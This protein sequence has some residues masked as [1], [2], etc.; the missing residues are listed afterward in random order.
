MTRNLLIVESPNKIKKIKQYLGSDWQ[1]EASVGH[2]CDLP[3]NEMGIAAPDYKPHYENDPKKSGVI[4]R[5]RSAVKS[6]QAIYIGTDPDRE[7]EAI[8]W[9]LERVLGLKQTGK[10]VYRATF[11]AINKTEI[12]RGIQSRGSI[13]YHLVAAQEARRVIDR[14][15]GYTVSPVLGHG[16]SAGRV[17]SVALRLIVERFQVINTF[18]SVEHYDVLANVSDTP[19]WNAKWNF[20][21]LTGEQGDANRKIWTDRSV[22]EQVA[23]TRQLQVLEVEKTRFIRKPL[24]PLRLLHYNRRLHGYWGLIPGTP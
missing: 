11:K 14:L 10:P 16:L 13:D 18:R 7:G 1:V 6:C 15:V 21:P 17:Q 22:A 5:L 2:F 20:K 23:Q 8:G 24:Q 4:S 3:K 12:Q 19:Q 9:H